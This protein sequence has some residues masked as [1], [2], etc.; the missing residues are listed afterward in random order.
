MLA[1]F[2][3]VGSEARIPFLGCCYSMSGLLLRNLN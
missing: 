1:F 2:E 3:S